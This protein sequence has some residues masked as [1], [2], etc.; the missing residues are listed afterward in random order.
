VLIGLGLILLIV[1]LRKRSQSATVPSSS[2]PVTP[3]GLSD[4]EQARLR[5]LLKDDQ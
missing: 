1:Q 5:A 2:A 3:S 4:A